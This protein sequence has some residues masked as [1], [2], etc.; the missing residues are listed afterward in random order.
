MCERERER[1][2]HRQF[3]TLLTGYTIVI[4]AS[5]LSTIILA[6]IKLV[7]LTG[8]SGEHNT[9]PNLMK[10][11]IELYRGDTHVNLSDQYQSLS[12]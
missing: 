3:H 10:I 9:L 4:G 6:L 2:N 7:I 11:S 12:I 5:I 1:E 8:I